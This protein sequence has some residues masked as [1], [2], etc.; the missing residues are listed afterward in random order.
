MR[1]IFSRKYRIRV[2]YLERLAN[3]AWRPFIGRRKNIGNTVPG[4]IIESAF[5]ID[6]NCQNI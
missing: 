6:L 3:V 2:S 4:N 1:G 5:M